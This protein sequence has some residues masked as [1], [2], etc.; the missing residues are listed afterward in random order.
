MSLDV[1]SPGTYSVEDAERYLSMFPDGFFSGI[2][3]SPP[4]NKKFNKRTLRPNASNWQ[5]SEI[6][7]HG[8]DSYSDNMPEDE[9]I[10]WQRRF[11]S[12]AVRTT[13]EDGVVMYNIGRRIHDL[14][15]DRRSA[16]V[17][18]FYVRQTII[19]NRG[20]TNNQ[21]GS[22]PTIFPPIYELVYV[23]AGPKWKLPEKHVAE[24]RHWGDVW[25]IP[26]EIGTEHPAPFPLAL[27]VRMAKTCGDRICDPFAG[28]GTL[29]VAGEL[30]GCEWRLNDIS[31]KYK[32]MFEKRMQTEGNFLDGWNAAVSGKCTNSMPMSL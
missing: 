9:Y 11:L 6:M 14:K 3:T 26:F 17:E 2:A 32:E 4:Y 21:G 13:G 1:P 31:E 8:Y 27:A 29:G 18:G 24:M 20:S 30:L 7:G 16:I 19:W 10:E 25:H 15:E 12:E 23:I 5:S 22:R 28:S